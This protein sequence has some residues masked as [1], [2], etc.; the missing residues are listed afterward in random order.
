[1]WQQQKW[2][3]RAAAL[4]VALGW[5]L[6][7]VCVGGG[8]VGG[9][10]RPAF[11]YRPSWRSEPVA[12]PQSPTSGRQRS[13]GMRDRPLWMSVALP[14]DGA[15][16]PPPPAHAQPLSKRQQQQQQP[17]RFDSYTKSLRRAVAMFNHILH[18]ILSM[19]DIFGSYS[20]PP[21]SL[22]VGEGAFSSRSDS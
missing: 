10:R 15:T 16:P 1:M 5:S 22:A 13:G 21:K 8:A 4:V 7:L 19:G 9:R 3:R 12:R 18:L 2:S 6:L 20:T 17:H 14:P 11:A